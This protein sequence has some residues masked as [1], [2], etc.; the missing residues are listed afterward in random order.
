MFEQ[1]AVH[2]LDDLVAPSARRGWVALVSTANSDLVDR[3]GRLLERAEIP[4][5][6]EQIVQDVTSDVEPKQ[7]IAVYVSESCFDRACEVVARDHAE[8]SD[9]RDE[10]DEV[11]DD[12]NGE[13]L[14]DD[15]DDDDG[16]PLHDDDDAAADGDADADVFD[17]DSDDHSGGEPGEL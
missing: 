16:G 5:L 8:N 13:D 10:E 14:D 15:P 11:L 9:G 1:R 6:L 4:F 12:D 3:Y 2:G 17:D 7:T